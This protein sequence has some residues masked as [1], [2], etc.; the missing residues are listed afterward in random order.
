MRKINKRS[1][2]FL[3]V[4]ALKIYPFF[5]NEIILRIERT[6]ELLTEHLFCVMYCL[7]GKVRTVSLSGPQPARSV[8]ERLLNWFGLSFDLKT[9]H[10]D[11]VHNMYMSSNDSSSVETSHYFFTT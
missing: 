11:G 7:S 3:L 10:F 9:G 5:S 6:R 8:F 2:T 1:P 4:V